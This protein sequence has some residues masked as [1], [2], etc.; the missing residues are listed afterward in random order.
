MLSTTHTCARSD[1]TGKLKDLVVR[2]GMKAMQYLL[3]AA[4]LIC[5]QLTEGL[6]CID[7]TYH[8]GERYMFSQIDVVGKQ[9]EC[10]SVVLKYHDEKKGKAI[11]IRK[12]AFLTQG[13]YADFQTQQ[14]VS[15]YV[16]TMPY[17]ETKNYFLYLN[18]GHSFAN[19]DSVAPK[20]KATSNGMTVGKIR[21]E[22]RT[23]ESQSGCSDSQIEEKFNAIDQDFQFSNKIK[24]ISTESEETDCKNKEMT[25]DKP[26]TPAESRCYTE[27]NLKEELRTMLDRFAESDIQFEGLMG[28]GLRYVSRVNP[29]IVTSPL[30]TRKACPESEPSFSDSLF[31]GTDSITQIPERGDQTPRSETLQTDPAL[32]KDL[33]WTLTDFRPLD[34]PRLRPRYVQPF[35]SEPLPINQQNPHWRMQQRV[36]R[37]TSMVHLSAS[38][39]LDVVVLADAGLYYD[40]DKDEMCCCRCSWRTPRTQFLEAGDPLNAHRCSQNTEGCLSH[41]ENEAEQDT[42]SSTHQTP[43]EEPTGDDGRR[44]ASDSHTEV[45]GH[46][47]NIQPSSLPHEGNSV[48][49]RLT[50]AD[51]P[52]EDAASEIQSPMEAMDADDQSV[53]EAVRSDSQSPSEIVQLDHDMSHDENPVSRIDSSTPVLDVNTAGVN[54][55]LGYTN[56]KCESNTEEWREIPHLYGH[57]SSHHQ[58]LNAQYTGD[59]EADGDK[60]VTPPRQCD[61]AKLP[62]DALLI[63]NYSSQADMGESC[64]YT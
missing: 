19:L 36:Y 11:S 58:S 52:S 16:N 7:V 26:P 62:G 51:L 39:P 55:S 21:R 53:S 27:T 10:I 59:L 15:E 56:F 28:N 22:K 14:I 5:P 1:D 8:M 20:A 32:G 41:D 64:N 29:T 35:R 38:L 40:E 48:N 60:S 63:V 18:A 4:S 2:M 25:F 24:Y 33:H 17:L 44:E 37:I 34:S 9:M 49:H 42:E 3:H 47:Q 13:D 43:Q 50:S 30:P 45:D 61:A 12:M 6:D 57:F 46:V 54:T 31:H 23:T